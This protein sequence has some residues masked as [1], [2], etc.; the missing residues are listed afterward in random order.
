MTST[1]YLAGLAGRFKKPTFVHRNGFSNEMLV[2]ASRVLESRKGNSKKIILG[3]ASGTLTHNRDIE[4]I[5][6]VLRKLL[7]RN[8]NISLWFIGPLTL[9]REWEKCRKQIIHLP[10]VPWRLLPGYLA[11]FDI[12]LAPLIINNPFAQSKS[13]I[14]WMEAALVHV[15]TVASATSAYKSAIKN[16]QNG[17]LAVTQDEWHATLSR[18]VN[19][20]K[21]RREIGET[22]YDWVIRN[23][24]PQVRSQEFLKIIRRIFP[25]VST[26]VKKVQPEVSSREDRGDGFEVISYKEKS[27]S[28][29][30]MAVYNFRYR[31]L[32]TV[33]RQVWVYFRRMISPV[34]PYR[35]TGDRPGGK[36]N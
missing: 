22:A 34:I 12:N 21:L 27:P 25:G 23:Y 18:L 35:K 13:E 6:P 33:I 9:S 5:G 26:S 4:S 31:G 28:L 3:Y 14:K 7:E 20:Q 8:A 2:T 15:P 17:F 29:F 11:R 24:S 30:M 10:H 16:G 19:D 36:P 32:S 1:D